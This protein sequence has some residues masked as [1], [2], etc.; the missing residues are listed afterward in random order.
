MRLSNFLLLQ[1]SYAKLV[2]LKEIWTDFGQS[3]L[4]E[5]VGEYS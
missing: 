3:D 1:I 2:I 5:A 4:F